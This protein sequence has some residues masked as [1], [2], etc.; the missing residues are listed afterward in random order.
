[1]VDLALWKMMEWKSVGMMTFPFLNGKSIQIPWF[2]TTNQNN[3]SFRHQYPT[4]MSGLFSPSFCRQLLKTV[5]TF[6]S[7][8]IH[9]LLA[10]KAGMWPV[11]LLLLVILPLDVGSIFTHTQWVKLVDVRL[12][13]E[14]CTSPSGEYSPKKVAKKNL[15]WLVTTDR[16]MISC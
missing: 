9:F 2:Q 10:G 3:I 4:N 11:R 14:P 12:W 7:F 16:L 6:L 5:F 1:M 13:L 15:P 8:D